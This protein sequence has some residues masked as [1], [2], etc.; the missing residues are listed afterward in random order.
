VV[1]GLVFRDVALV[2]NQRMVLISAPERWVDVSGSPEKKLR[3]T[4]PKEG[5]NRT[6]TIK[7]TNA[8]N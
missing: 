4:L 3:N 8:T 6:Y 5:A 1:G 2:S 7:F